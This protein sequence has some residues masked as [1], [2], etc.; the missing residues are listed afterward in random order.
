MM[1]IGKQ[2]IRCGNYEDRSNQIL[3]LIDWSTDWYTMAIKI[4]GK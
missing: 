1:K 4:M 3:Q 2:S